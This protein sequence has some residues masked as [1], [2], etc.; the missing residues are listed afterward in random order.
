MI[1]KTINLFDLQHNYSIIEH[2]KEEVDWDKPLE[3]GDKVAVN[4]YI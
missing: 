1:S 4:V 2:C 3:K